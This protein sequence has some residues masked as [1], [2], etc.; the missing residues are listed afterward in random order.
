MLQVTPTGVTD[1]EI[2]GLFNQ[3]HTLSSL[4]DVLDPQTRKTLGRHGT[5][6]SSEKTNGGDKRCRTR[7]QKRKGDPSPLDDVHPVNEDPIVPIMPSSRIFSNRDNMGQRTPPGTEEPKG[8]CGQRRSPRRSEAV[9]SG[10]E[11]IS[12]TDGI[13]MTRRS[14]GGEPGLAEARKDITSTT[15]F[16]EHH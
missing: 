1:A 6:P 3:Y 12:M 5:S 16:V 7:L 10:S 8:Q 11:H 13:S 2:S 9:S 15:R 4:L 14:F